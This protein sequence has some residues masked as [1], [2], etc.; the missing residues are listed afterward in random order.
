M[1]IEEKSAVK[2]LG[3]LQ[4]ALQW[5]APVDPALSIVPKIKDAA[6]ALILN[7]DI[8]VLT[9]NLVDAQLLSPIASVTCGR[10]CREP[11]APVSQPLREW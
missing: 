9:P 6:G 7:I 2:M 11:A 10:R 1:R 8:A 4:S 5:I 3:V